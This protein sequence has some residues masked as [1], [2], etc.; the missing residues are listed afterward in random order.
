MAL[1]KLDPA[2]I[3][4]ATATAITAIGDDLL[5]EIFLRLPSLPSLVRAALACRTFL[6]AVRTSPDFRRRF[7]AV[8]PPQ[9][10]GFFDH[11]LRRRGI[12][13]F[14]PFRSSSD[15]DL[16]AAVSGADFLLTRLPED[17]GDPGWEMNSTCCSYLVLHNKKTKQLAAYNPLTRALDIFP[18]P[19]QEAN[20]HPRYL[21]CHIT[22]S[23]EDPRS[24]RLVCVRCR[25]RRRRTLARFSVFSSDSREWQSFPWVDTSTPRLS[26]SSSSSS[27]STNDTLTNGCVYW[28]HKNQAYVVVLN[29]ATLQMS[30]MDLPPNMEDDCTDFRLGQT[31]DG[32]LCMAY[33]DHPDANMEVLSVCCW[34]A[35]SDGVSRLMTHKV[36]PKSTFIDAAMCSTGDAV[37]ME[38]SAVIDGFVFLSINYARWNDCLVS[39]CLETE[40]VNK[41]IG[42][43]YYCH[44]HPYIMAW[45]PSLVGNKEDLEIKVTGDNVADDGPVGTEGTPSVLAMTL[46][47]YKEALI[48]GDG[49][50]VSEIEAF[51]LS[52]EDEKKSLVAELTTARDCISRISAGTDGYRGGAER[53]G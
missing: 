40:N 27:S 45:P 7:L 34:S 48:N 47:S 41:L 21:A 16:A 4:T 18:C 12:P 30:R 20:C 39:F 5:R 2:A 29:T 32:H 19:A 46:Q 11:P 36:F 38:V 8:H 43:T 49:A 31:K 10:L 6:R 35:D 3:A 25:R 1:A 14:V 17:S 24:F 42:H 22:V 26:S 13:A 52:I 33:I 37:M 53:E 28:K 9:I 15:P 44:M 23:E 51:L 50:K